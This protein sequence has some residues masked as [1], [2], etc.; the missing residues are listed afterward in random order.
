MLVVVDDCLTIT[1]IVNVQHGQEP[2]VSNSKYQMA[3]L[4][5]PKL[6]IHS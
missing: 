2:F 3:T 5:K 6:N 4:D 1:A